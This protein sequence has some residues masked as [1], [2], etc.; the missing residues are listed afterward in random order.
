MQSNI[1]YINPDILEKITLNTKKIIE[2]QEETNKRLEI[3]KD[4]EKTRKAIKQEY[5][6]LRE[7]DLVNDFSK[8]ANIIYDLLIAHK[9]LTLE[10]ISKKIDLDIDDTLLI[11]QIDKRF[12]LNITTGRFELDDFKYN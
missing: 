2:L 12:K 4:I 10:Q 7:K 1:S 8:E 9:S 6:K 3:A 5:N 11:L